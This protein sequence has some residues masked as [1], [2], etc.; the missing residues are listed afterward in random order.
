[1]NRVQPVVHLLILAVNLNALRHLRLAEHLR[2]VLFQFLNVIQ[3]FLRE[4]IVQLLDRRRLLL[5]HGSR[6]T[7][8]RVRVVVPGNKSKPLFVAI[9]LLEFLDGIR[10]ACIDEPIVF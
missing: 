4:A 6:V 10:Q 7:C 5:Q 1:M 8:T 9:V 3:I 2:P